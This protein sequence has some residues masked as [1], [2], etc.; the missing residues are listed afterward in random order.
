[1]LPMRRIRSTCLFAVLLCLTAGGKLLAQSDC[2]VSGR[3]FRGDGTPAVNETITIVKIEQNGNA[4][5]F[6][7]TAYQSDSN[8]YVTFTVPRNSDAWVQANNV[9]G[10]NVIGGIPL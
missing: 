7:S 1:M 3:I 10:L 8:G 4:V 2:T 6:T 5:P 9:T